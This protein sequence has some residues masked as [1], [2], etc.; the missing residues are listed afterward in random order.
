MRCRSKIVADHDAKEQHGTG[1]ALPGSLVGQRHPCFAA[2]GTFP[3]G[4]R[5]LGVQQVDYF[6]IR[7]LR[8]W[9]YRVGDSGNEA[10]A[11]HRR[12]AAPYER[13]T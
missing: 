13:G 6:V 1:E 2:G 9:Q 10:S 5:R 7:S 4:Q 12:S 11:I 3:E 8:R